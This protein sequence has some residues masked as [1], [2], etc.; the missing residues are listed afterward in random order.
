MKFKSGYVLFLLALAVVFGAAVN[1]KS[2]KVKDP[3]GFAFVPMGTMTYDEDTTSVQAFFMQTTEVTNLQYRTFLNDLKAK[4]DMDAYKKAMVD[5]T[6][7][8][9]P[10][11][12]Q[13]PMVTYYFSH[14]AYDKYPVVNITREGAELYCKW[15]SE[16]WRKENPDAKCDFRLPTRAEWIMAARGGFQN[17]P[18]PWGGPYLRNSKGC[19]MCNF[20]PLGAENIQR[21]S[22]TGEF[23]VA[24][25]DANGYIQDGALTTMI[26]GHYSPND[27]GLYDMSGNVAEMVWE[28]GIVV[29]GSWYSTGYDVRVESVMEFT[30]ANPMVG[31]RPVMTYLGKESN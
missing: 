30:E 3:K 25:T 12:Y 7:W 1:K 16:N 6:K 24:S 19:Y 5:S 21:N 15:L 29:G 18:Y 2:Y 13:E 11:A 14:P 17:T 31:F 22:E 10:N 23:E 4:G 20:N 9:F 26:V 8:R 28:E 27:Y